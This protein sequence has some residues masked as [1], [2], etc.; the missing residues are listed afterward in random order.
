MNHKVDKNNGLPTCLETLNGRL[1]IELLGWAE[2]NNGRMLWQ[3]NCSFDDKS[4]NQDVFSNN[5]NYININID[6]IQICDDTERYY[7]I[8]VEGTAILIDSTL[9]EI[10]KLPYVGTSTS[11]FQ[12]STFTEEF[13]IQTYFNSIVLTNLKSHISYIYH[14]KTGQNFLKTSLSSRN[15]ITIRFY[16]V[17]NQI[18]TEDDLIIDI[19]KFKKL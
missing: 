10:V 7:F 14:E 17:E 9:K 15:Q 8:P 2:P 19:S 6:N 1:K 12:S 18:R 5:W 11:S 4:I 3:A 13:L 16:K